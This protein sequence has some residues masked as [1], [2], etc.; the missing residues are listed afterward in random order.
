MEEFDA[1]CKYVR[2]IAGRLE[3]NDL[4]YFYARYKQVTEGACNTPKPSFYQLSE[5]SKWFAWTEL[6]NLDKCVARDEYIEKLDILEP[7]WRGKEAQDPTAG[8]ISVSC[9]RPEEQV[10][11]QDKTIWDRVRDG[12][13]DILKKIL[14]VENV[15][16]KDE[17]GMSLLHWAADRGMTEVAELLISLDKTLIN[18]QVDTLC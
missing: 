13:L 3:N 8:W 9:P 1:A 6:G 18:L 10:P 16:C 14:T 5:K 7:E 11:E 4:L 17:N 2:G 15:R 12:D